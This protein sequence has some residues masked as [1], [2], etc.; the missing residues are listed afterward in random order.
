MNST[1][2]TL[3]YAGQDGCR[4]TAVDGT[5]TVRA[6]DGATLD[7]TVP[8]GVLLGDMARLLTDHAA[9]L[10]IA[11]DDAAIAGAAL[12]CD[13]VNDIAQLHGHFHPTAVRAVRR[14]LG[15]LAKQDCLDE[16]IDSF[17]Q[18]LTSTLERGIACHSA[19]AEIDE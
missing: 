8:N 19:A 16:A 1:D 13:L 12:A 3:I 6:S 7:I 9:A 2:H 18:V 15:N 14:A 10:E 4:V 11:Q 5:L 17:A